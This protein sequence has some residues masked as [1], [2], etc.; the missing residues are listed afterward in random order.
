[1]YCSTDEEE[2]NGDKNVNLNQTCGNNRPK[3]SRGTI[4]TFRHIRMFFILCHW[5]DPRSYSSQ[6]C[7][8]E[9]TGTKR[10]T[11]SIANEHYGNKSHDGRYTNLWI[12][13]MK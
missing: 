5:D 7:I 3:W 11:S 8:Q 2:S 13:Y 9:L 1:M 12:V 10:L 4:L 6:F